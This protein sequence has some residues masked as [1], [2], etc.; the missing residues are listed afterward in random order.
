MNRS[1]RYIALIL[2]AIVCLFSCTACSSKKEDRLQMF[3]S[4]HSEEYMNAARKHFLNIGWSNSDYTDGALEYSHEYNGGA[5][6][7]KIGGIDDDTRYVVVISEDEGIL[8]CE[9]IDGK[10][11]SVFVYD[12]GSDDIKI[13]I[14]YCVG[15][16]ENCVVKGNVVSGEFAYNNSLTIKASEVSDPEERAVFIFNALHEALVDIEGK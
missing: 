10:G 3:S 15:T 13:S 9:P 8:T 4:G 1:I 14:H 6:N 5:V 16:T 7:I 2:A 12:N 11:Y